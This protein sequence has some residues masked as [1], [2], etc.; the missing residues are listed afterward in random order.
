M[1]S[2]EGEQ[3]LS[4]AM[5]ERGLQLLHR[6]N[7][8]SEMIIESD[9]ESRKLMLAEMLRETESELKMLGI[10]VDD[11]DDWGIDL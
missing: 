3:A 6:R 8:I 4:R 9:L 11:N 7:V 2:I 1:M 5:H 10:D